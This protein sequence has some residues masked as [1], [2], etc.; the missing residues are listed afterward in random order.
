[1]TISIN[2]AVISLPPVTDNNLALK[3]YSSE[4]YSAY[5]TFLSLIPIFT[6]GVLFLLIITFLF[7]SKLIAIE[8]FLVFQFTYGGL[9]MM[10]K[11]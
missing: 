6:Y 2:S 7:S 8:T 3:Y 9:I 5:Q 4:Q 10:K 11:I 1:M